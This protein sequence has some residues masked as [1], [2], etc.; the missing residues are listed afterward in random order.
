[1]IVKRLGKRDLEVCA[2]QPPGDRVR[3]L[4]GADQERHLEGVAVGERRLDEAGID[5]LDGH[6]VPVEIELQRF[7][8][9]DQR[10]LGGPVIGRC[11][12]A[13][14]AGDRRH[15]RDAAAAAADHRAHHRLQR[16]GDADQVDL[17]QAGQVG[18]PKIPRADRVMVAGRQHRYIDRAEIALDRV[19]DSHAP[20]RARSRRAARAQWH[21]H[22]RSDDSCV[23]ASRLRA[24]A[25]TRWPSRAKHKRQ[26]A[27]DAGAGTGD[28]DQP[29]LRTTG[30]RCAR[31]G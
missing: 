10:G 23:N 27:P 26:G 30:V 8:E 12:Q 11:G 2:L 4:L 21:R 13:A 22:A 18:G 31:T 3:R 24:L 17:D 28:P 1:M 19:M 14:I 29:A 15:D 7:G 5:Q 9:I 25:A 6:A 16:I 20:R